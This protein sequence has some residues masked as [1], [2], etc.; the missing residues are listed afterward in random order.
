MKDGIG[1]RMKANYENRFR[2]KLPRR[3]PVII[4]IDGKCFHTFTRGF[5]KP[6]DKELIGAMYYA[7]HELLK[8]I[9]GAK[10]AYIQSDEAS[11]LVTD[12]DNLE[13]EAWF[14]YNIQKMVSVSASIFTEKFNR[15]ITCR[16]TPKQANFDSRCFSI[17]K[18]EVCNYF[19]WRQQDW[20]RNSIMMFA[21]SFFSH[22]ELNGKKCADV[23]EMLYSKGEN[24][25]NL[26]PI[27]KNGTVIT[28][29]ERGT[30]E[31]EHPIIVKDRNV[32][33]SL[34]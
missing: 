14:D 1:D 6:F 20:K 32:I 7:T 16:R 22:K 34:I 33:E 12:Y 3:T 19:I 8:Q 25:A 2:Y 15:A 21:R 18:E 28:K 10:C 4:R 23:H 27:Y 17:P 31:M 9:S 30:F 26:E 11:I 13:T 24:W 29:T 5:D